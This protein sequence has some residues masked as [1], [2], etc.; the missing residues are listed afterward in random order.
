M[1]YGQKCEIRPYFLIP[2]TLIN[3][4]FQENNARIACTSKFFLN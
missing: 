2:E 3:K 4:G 1:E